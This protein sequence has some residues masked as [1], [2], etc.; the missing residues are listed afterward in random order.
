MG[1]P[2][3]DSNWSTSENERDVSTNHSST[4]GLNWDYP[5]ETMIY[6]NT[7]PHEGGDTPVNGGQKRVGHKAVAR[8]GVFSD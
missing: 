2:E 1:H 4:I 6:G 3:D 8:P 5:R 7:R